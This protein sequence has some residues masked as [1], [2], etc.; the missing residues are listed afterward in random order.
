[1]FFQSRFAWPRLAALCIVG[2]LIGLYAY[3]RQHRTL[4][5]P[6]AGSL[7]AATDDTAIAFGRG[8]DFFRL[9]PDCTLSRTFRVAIPSKVVAMKR[10][11]CGD[12]IAWTQRGLAYILSED[13]KFALLKALDCGPICEIQ[14]ATNDDILA[15]TEDGRLLRLN[16]IE[17]KVTFV[18]LRRP[19]GSHIHVLAAV[20]SIHDEC[21]WLLPEDRANAECYGMTGDFIG[22]VASCISLA[23]DHSGRVYCGTFHGTVVSLQRDTV[24]IIA[25]ERWKTSFGV[26]DLLAACQT[27]VVAANSQLSQIAICDKGGDVTEVSLPK[28]IKIRSIGA[29]ASSGSA[30]IVAGNER[31]F[32]VLRIE[33][34]KIC[35][36]NV[37]E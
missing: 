37:E 6:Y 9:N 32:H 28:N 29:L 11:P 10:R 19:D 18:R 22:N 2:C 14:F 26:V 27:T 7:F 21:V 23:T 4:S 30:S 8:I 12:Y 31:S 17:D 15:I 36:G 1:M 35:V 20:I 5:H 13:G 3:S 25:T 34:G 16:M 33:R 24:E